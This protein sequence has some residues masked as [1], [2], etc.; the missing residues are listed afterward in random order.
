MSRSVIIILFLITG[1]TLTAQDIPFD[2]KVGSF[3]EIPVIEND[4]V[5]VLLQDMKRVTGNFIV[6]EMNTVTIRN[7]ENELQ[8]I[9]AGDIAYFRLEY[10]RGGRALRTGMWGGI[11]GLFAGIPL[12]AHFVSQRA[13]DE[14]VSDAF[15]Y[16]GSSL[17]AGVVGGLMGIGY[18]LATTPGDVVYKIEQ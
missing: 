12:G 17:G 8:S 16:I 9:P 3:D 5:T 15:L 6:Y 10:D 2:K 1:T 13:A 4:R 11:V 18:G 7:K 14:S